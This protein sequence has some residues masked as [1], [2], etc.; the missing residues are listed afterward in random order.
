MQL[1][2]II[3]G[4]T[5]FSVHIQVPPVASP[6]KPERPIPARTS[7]LIRSPSLSDVAR[8]ACTCS[9]M[10]IF[11]PMQFHRMYRV[12]HS[13]PQSSY[14]TA[15]IYVLKEVPHSPSLSASPQCSDLCSSSPCGS[16]PHLT[17][18]SKSPFMYFI[19]WAS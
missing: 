19:V 14:V 1:E 17:S 9:P 16:R 5:V 6:A 10:C 15:G 3:Q 11:C 8:F 18:R 7:A 2:E 4:D 13:P 12:V